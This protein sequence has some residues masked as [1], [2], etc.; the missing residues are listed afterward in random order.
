MHTVKEKAVKNEKIKDFFKMLNS[1]LP[2][3]Y[4]E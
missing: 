3:G 2:W 4:G 1:D